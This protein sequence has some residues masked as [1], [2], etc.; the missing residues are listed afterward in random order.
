MAQQI[1]ADAIQAL[2]EG[3]QQLQAALNALILAQQQQLG[4]PQVPHQQ[5]QQMATIALTPALAQTGAIDSSSKAG[6]SVYK[7]APAPLET[8]F[9]FSSPNT[10][11]LLQ[12]M[13]IC[14]TNCGWMDILQVQNRV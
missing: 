2:I 9:N 7:A 12:E 10:R 4:A 3:Q 6:A 14:A 13:S 1:N 11:L 8:E 5:G